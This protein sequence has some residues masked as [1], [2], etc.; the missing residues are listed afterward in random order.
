EERAEVR[1]R[2]RPPE[3]QG[4]L[5]LVAGQ[6]APDGPARG[7][8]RVWSV[9]WVGLLPLRRVDPQLPPARPHGL[10]AAPG[11]LC[12]LLGRQ[13]A[14]Q[15]GIRS[16]P[17]APPARPGPYWPETSA[18]APRRCAACP[19]VPGP[20]RGPTPA[21]RPRPW[22]MAGGWLLLFPSLGPAAAA[23]IAGMADVTQVLAAIERGDPRAAE[24]LLPLVYD[25]LRRL[26]A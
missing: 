1:P 5:R 20:S 6:V 17:G 12:R 21:A 13:R 2:E 14:H 3:L 16:R 4:A 22:P 8:G 24:Q 15:H 7:W 19:G 9:R 11:T 23:I 10:D 26:A 25:E 18:A